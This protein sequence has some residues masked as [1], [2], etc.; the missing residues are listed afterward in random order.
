MT[1]INAKAALP[2]ATESTDL[3]RAV[4]SEIN[5]EESENVNLDELFARATKRSPDDSQETKL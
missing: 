1:T 3:L 4:A 2:K 5:K